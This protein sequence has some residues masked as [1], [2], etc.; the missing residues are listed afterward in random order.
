MYSADIKKIER[1]FIPKDF[2]VTNWETLEP[3]FKDLADRDISAKDKLEQ[4]L[5]D[6]SE[7]EAVVNEDSCWRQI[8][9]TC[10]TENKDLEDSF[11]Y[12]FLEI[13]PKIQP[14]SDIL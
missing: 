6:Q 9:M 4:W 2:T 14:Y 8:R 13:Q 10:D 7:L 11:N 12:F 5:K 3:Y 1:H